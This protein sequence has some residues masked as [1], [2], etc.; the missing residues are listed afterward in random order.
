M[1]VRDER[2]SPRLKKSARYLGDEAF[3]SSSKLQRHLEQIL[4]TL[5]HL[6]GFWLARRES[7]VSLPFPS[8]QRL[9]DCRRTYLVTSSGVVPGLMGI[10]GA[11]SDG[12]ISRGKKRARS[13]PH[14]VGVESK[15]E[16]GNGSSTRPLLINV[17]S[18][19]ASRTFPLEH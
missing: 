6:P 3:I 19:L 14:L 1:V 17:H 12:K 13:Y 4:P 15:Q 9:I 18:P 11:S 2:G 10:Q 16:I 8:S 7:F 5:L